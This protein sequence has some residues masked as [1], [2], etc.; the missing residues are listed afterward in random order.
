M[1]KNNPFEAV[2]DYHKALQEPMP[3]TYEEVISPHYGEED[4]Y[5]ANLEK[6]QAMLRILGTLQK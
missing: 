3:S 6:A 5:I 2:E 1:I 4:Q